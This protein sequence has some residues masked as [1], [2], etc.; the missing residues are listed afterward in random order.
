MKVWSA[1][2][3]WLRLPFTLPHNLFSILNFLSQSRG[4][5]LRKGLVMIWSGVVWSLWRR[6]NVLFFHNGRKENVEVI[7]EIKMVT[8]KCWLSQ[9]K[10]A[11]CL[12]YEWYMEPILCMAR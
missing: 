3:Q 1:I 12:L 7:E 2:F 10:V 8:W 5:K 6:W 11:H 4:K 9:S